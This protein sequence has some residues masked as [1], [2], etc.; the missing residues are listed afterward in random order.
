[1]ME[2]GKM[3]NCISQ[4]SNKIK[5]TKCYLNNIRLDDQIMSV[6]Q[7]FPTLL[8]ILNRMNI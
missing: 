1:M 3:L 5:D 8:L 7:T 4:N 6:S 2:N